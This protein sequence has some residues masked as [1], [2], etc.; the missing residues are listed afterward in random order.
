MPR[1]V[2]IYITDNDVTGSSNDEEGNIQGEKSEGHNRICKEILVENGNTRVFSKQ[3]SSR[4]NKDT[5]LL[6]ENIEKYRGVRL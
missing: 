3:M 6:Q 4:E 5:K 1:V 2:H